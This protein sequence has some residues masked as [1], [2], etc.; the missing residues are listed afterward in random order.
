MSQYYT[1]FRIDEANTAKEAKFIYESL[2]EIFSSKKVV[3]NMNESMSFAS[4]ASGQVGKGIV[5]DPMIARL[6]K[7]AN[8]KTSK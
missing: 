3:K 1:P 5:V 8:I 2:N 4:K 6:Q 7:L